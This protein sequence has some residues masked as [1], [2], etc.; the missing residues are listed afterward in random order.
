MNIGKST[1]NV[2]LLKNAMVAL[3][4]RQLTATGQD[5]NQA[6]A[7]ADQMTSC[8][9]RRGEYDVCLD[10]QTEC[11]MRALSFKPVYARNA[12]VK[13]VTFERLDT[14]GTLLDIV[15]VLSAVS[16]EYS[17]NEI[18]HKQLLMSDTIGIEGV[19]NGIAVEIELQ[20]PADVTSASGTF[21][22]R[23]FETATGGESLPDQSVS[24][25]VEGNSA[26]L[27]VFLGFSR[28]GSTRVYPRAFAAKADFANVV[29]SGF[30]KDTTYNI[31]IGTVL[32]TVGQNALA[33]V[34][35]GLVL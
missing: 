2:A 11:R 4:A 16:N 23:G 8:N 21:T 33:S 9:T 14:F 32:N 10:P 6:A 5:P 28:T 12:R 7:I 18:V 31:R 15:T 20:L 29:I 30:P 17:S 25:I 3:I 24:C 22:F 26:T 35:G 27:Q 19:A 1:I 13:D 34:Q